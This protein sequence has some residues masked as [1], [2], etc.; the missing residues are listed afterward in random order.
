[1]NKKSFGFILA[2]VSIIW[3]SVSAKAET[4]FTANLSGG[5][6]VPA[7]ASTATGFGRV[8]L[9][10]AE[11]SITASFHFSSLGTGTTAGHIHGPAAPG[12][13]APVIFDMA[14]TGGQTTGNVI[15]RV[16]A[17]TPAQVADLKAGLWYFNIHTTGFGGG[18]IR[19]QLT[20]DSPFIA[21]M[22]GGQENP[23]RTTSATGSGAISLNAAGTQALVTMKWA[24]LTGNTTAGHIHSGR[25]GVNGPVICDLAPAAAVSGAVVDF[26]CTFTVAQVTALKQAQLYLNLHTSMFTG[27]EIRGQIQRRR[28]TVMDF[29]GD[30]RTDYAIARNNAGANQIEWWILN[31][32]GGVS[33]FPFG[34]SAEFNTTRM[35]AG[36]F[37]GDG[38]DDVAIWRS[39]ESP[40][41][42]FLI[43]QSSDGAVRFEQFGTTND[44]PRVVYDYDGDGKCDP[45][46]FRT[47]DDTWYYLGSSNNPSRNIAF[48]RFGTT[49]ANPGDY[50]GDGRG[51]FMDQQ[52][53][54]WWILNSSDNSVK[55]VQ[56]GTSSFFG[57]PGDYDGDGKTDVAGSVNEGS[58]LTWYY[59]SSLNPSQN[60]F[61]T[62]RPFGPTTG[63]TRTQG[64]YDGDG[65]TDVAVWIS[66]GIPAFWA[67][68]SSGSSPTVV[69]WGVSTDF[70][71][72][73]YNNR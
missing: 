30:S 56:F 64:D 60:V 45:A 6:E 66:S 36:D 46:V 32:A 12:A 11:N 37:D 71:L 4:Y 52:N 35:V 42:G 31:N 54:N 25:S 43:L 59:A 51:D 15:N 29:D 39:A 48:I 27:G 67:L 40:N 1:M 73:G 38:R 65:K 41:A 57:V 44:D 2:V 13:N 49:F 8:T 16:F 69:S 72:V 62:R 19:G 10:N 50:D 53:N 23:A 61:L 58:N 7:N 17:V 21:Y 18:E 20:I 70:P 24:G 9:N 33:A 5:Q 26:L 14:P 47:S 22:T 55:V 28:S 34:V 68:P 3:F 63:R